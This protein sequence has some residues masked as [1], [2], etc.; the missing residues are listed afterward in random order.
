M[1]GPDVS[2]PDAAP[3]RKGNRLDR[4]GRGGTI[5]RLGTFRESVARLAR[6]AEEAETVIGIHG[7]SVTTGPEQRPHSVGLRDAVE[8]EFTVHRTP[9]YRDP[10]HCT[11]EL[12][13]PITEEVAERF[14]F[15]FGR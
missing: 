13:K 7:V 6:K 2:D 1:R 14:N 5:K 12:P 10:N 8:A 9:T 4:T 3:R 15:L 11:V